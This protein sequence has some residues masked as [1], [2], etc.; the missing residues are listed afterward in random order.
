[1]ANIDL[2]KEYPNCLDKGTCEKIIK[3]FELDDRKG[4]GRTASG[5]QKNIKVS[6]DL[7]I[8]EYEDWKEYDD[9]FFN[10]VTKKVQPYLENLRTAL[11]YYDPWDG[12]MDT[13]YQ[14]QKTEPGG[15]YH[16]HN[17]AAMSIVSTE[18][19]NIDGDIFFSGIQRIF[20]YILYLNDVDV[21][22]C[23]GRTQFYLDQEIHSITPEAGK[24]LLFPANTLYT[25]RGETLTDGL[26]YLMTGWVSCEHPIP[27]K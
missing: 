13:G 15:F 20:T 9:I 21:E 25:H 11:K 4:S 24:L 16:W 17:D 1:M 26:K 12:I 14:I 19:T 27:L 6:T 23:G 7:M 3:K 2:V 18:Q 8:S 10:I 5:E 22:N